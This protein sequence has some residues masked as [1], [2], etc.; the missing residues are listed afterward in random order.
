MKKMFLLAILLSGIVCALASYACAETY[1]GVLYAA[2]ASADAE[3]VSGDASTES[4]D[5]VTEIII[6]TDELPDG[7]TGNSY[8]AAI[9]ANISDVTW[10]VISGTL[11]SG[12]TLSADGT[13]SGTPVSAGTSTFI[14][15]AAS[16][17]LFPVIKE[18]SITIHEANAAADE[19]LAVSIITT[20]I[21]NGTTGVSYY[22]E[23]A[24]NPPDTTWSAVK[25]LPAGLTFAPEGVITGTPIVAGSFDLTVIASS[26]NASA[27]R[28]VELRIDPLVITTE[29]L[30]SGT[31]GHTV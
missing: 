18:L 29:K 10:S 31:K 28:T 3:A 22:A 7:M 17:L 6:S 14:A 4:E 19:I 16:D 30:P 8:G 24:S 1:G 25:R 27:V 23:F 26:G 20:T 9:T 13:I 21:P 12:L 2:E 5:A 11:P 15:E